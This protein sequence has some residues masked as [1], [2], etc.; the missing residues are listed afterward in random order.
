MSAPPAE[1][2]FADQS[3]EFRLL[4][5]LDGR[6]E[7]LDERARQQLG[8]DVGARLRDL[9]P[10]GASDKLGRMLAAIAS[11]EGDDRPWEVMLLVRGAPEV[12]AL[13]GRRWQG[14]RLALTASLVPADYGAVLGQLGHN[15]AEAVALHRETDRQQRELLRRHEEL[16]RLHRELEESFRAVVVLHG[17]LGDRDDSL[18]RAGEFKSRLV[19]NVSHEFR[20]PLNSIIGLTRLLLGRSDGDL[21]PE[22]EVQLTFIQQSADALY[23]L[24]NDLLDLSKNE[25]GRSVLRPERFDVAGLFASLRGMMRPLVSSDQVALVL[26]EPAG[27]ADM[28][29]DVGKVAQILRNLIGNA[30]KFTTR[31][32]VRVAAEAAGDGAV[33]FTVRDTGIG[34]A[35]ADQARIFEEF[36]QVDSPLQRQVKGSGL[37]LALSRQLAERL[38]GTLTVESAPGKGSTFTLVIPS[39]H[40]EVSE[41]QGMVERSRAVTTGDQPVLVVEDD[42][43]TLFLYEKYLRGSGFAVIPAR[44]VEQARE[45]LKGMT[46]AAIVLDVMLEGESTWTFLQDLKT[47]EATRT[48]PVLVVTVTSREEQAR[49]LGADEFFLKPM[50]RDLL[51]AKLRS[52]AQRRTVDSVLVIDDDDVSRYL[53]RK[54]LDG[55]P[56]RVL[57]ASNGDAGL[58]IA[59]KELPSV[60]FLDFVL[61]DMSAFDV[62]DELKRDPN[63]RSIPVI[64][65][66]SKN[67]AEEERKRLAVSASTILSKHSLSRE[68]AIG[69]IRDVLAHS[70]LAK[71][72]EPSRHG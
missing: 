45:V 1:E 19:A 5:A 31:G 47:G 11:G 40:L 29:T 67:L 42:R 70:G 4:C 27:L 44:S 33:R 9:S 32:E 60:I 56:Y 2:A 3:R 8:A 61:G 7:W 23:V 34:I 25:A 36:Y 15:M 52:M 55:L 48:I 54:H 35:P 39:R 68:I 18:R 53:V 6:I 12:L 51:L 24:V 72:K 46:P 30:L 57:E 26:D 28:E 66:T 37:G 13:R 59:R 69:R 65:H 50:E 22:Q 63:T 17:E 16:A 43:Q 38:G 71:V 62:L 41:F 20:T 49:A 64:I 14:D 21:T 58:R 10:E